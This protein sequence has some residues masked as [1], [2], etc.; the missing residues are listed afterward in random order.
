[1]ISSGVVPVIDLREIFRQEATS[2]IV[3]SA[4]AVRSGQYPNTADVS[5]EPGSLQGLSTYIPSDGSVV[6]RTKGDVIPVVE[7][8]VSSIA[9]R[10]GVQLGSIQ[11]ISP[12]RKGPLGVNSLNPKLQEILNPPG[13]GKLEISRG[14]TVLRL[15]DRVLQ[16]HNDYDK[17]VYNGDQGTIVDVD[18]IS[19]KILVQ[20]EKGFG[21][22]HQVLEYS[23]RYCAFD[24]LKVERYDFKTLLFFTHKHASQYILNVVTCREWILP[25]S[26]SPM[27][28]LCIRHKEEKLKT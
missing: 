19:N 4:L 22:T 14:D 2:S 11:V 27:L 18:P 25:I 23:V 6:L 17:D 21:S 10:P 16:L 15:G 20:F 8:A 9:A 26:I 28:L 5:V 3:T 24:F 1:M 7:G 13:L 12:M